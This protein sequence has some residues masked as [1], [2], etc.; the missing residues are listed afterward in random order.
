MKSNWFLLLY[1]LSNQYKNNIIPLANEPFKLHFVFQI[2]SNCKHFKE[3]SGDIS[4]ACAL[5]CYFK[6]MVRLISSSP[7]LCTMPCEENYYY[8][9]N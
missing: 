2:L 4:S 7:T 8:Q 5:N 3:N 1:L 9:R 6:R